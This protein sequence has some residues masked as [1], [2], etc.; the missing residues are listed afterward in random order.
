MEGILIGTLVLWVLSAV[1]V[2]PLTQAGLARKMAAAG[3]A[4]RPL[5]EF[6]EAEQAHW[7]S[8]ATQQYILWDVVVLGTAGLIGG[9]LG[10]YFIGISMES[11]GWPG[12]I[13]FIAASFLG[14]GICGGSQ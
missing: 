14:L 6:S 13:V 7:K 8:I 3:V 10:F 11:K 1:L 9:L 2:V 12:M 5:E 4:D